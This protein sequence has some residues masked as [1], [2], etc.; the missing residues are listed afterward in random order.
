MV[1]EFFT[2]PRGTAIGFD[3]AGCFKSR[4]ISF[5]WGKMKLIENDAVYNQV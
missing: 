3:H 5:I 4:W 1:M 2:P